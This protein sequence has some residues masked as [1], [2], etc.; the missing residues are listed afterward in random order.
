[1]NKIAKRILSI[2]MIVVLLFTVKVIAT[3]NLAVEN[4]VINYDDQV[5]PISENYE[6]GALVPEEWRRDA[7]GAENSI[8][9]D[10][11]FAS[12][13]EYTLEDK[14]I[15]GDMFLC[16]IDVDL[17]NVTITGNLFMFAEN[18]TLENVSV[19]GS[20]YMFAI[21]LESKDLSVAGTVYLLAEDTKIESDEMSINDLYVVSTESLKINAIISRDAKI[22]GENIDV[23]N[24]TVIGR[25]FV[26]PSDE[27]VTIDDGVVVYGETETYEANVD[28]T[29][30]AGTN[31]TVE[32]NGVKDILSSII[33]SVLVTG[34]VLLLVVAFSEK[35][36]KVSKMEPREVNL[37]KTIGKGFLFFVASIAIIIILVFTVIGIPL[38]IMWLLAII[39]FAFISEPVAAIAIVSALSKDDNMSK[40]KIYGLSLI[41]LVILALLDNLSLGFVGFVISFA[42]TCLGFGTL[43]NAITNK[44][45]KIKTKKAKKVVVKNDVEDSSIVIKENIKVEKAKEVINEAEE[46]D[47]ETTDENV[48][49]LNKLDEID[50]ENK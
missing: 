10:N 20:V 5:M 34:I 6:E 42:V 12:G 49:V 46:S 43:Y 28:E 9:N 48:D 29:N 22:L 25:N 7:I 23:E 35:L 16:A 33:A 27:N 36:V 44:D 37:F 39:L 21:D 26:Y 24:G 4:E 38:S 17:K 2:V 18:A 47:E 32:K 19:S 13:E 30:N 1:M 14:Y 15:Q 40:T 31:V 45:E 3:E 11:V 41:V 8:I 50:N